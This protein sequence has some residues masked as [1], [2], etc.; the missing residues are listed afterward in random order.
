MAPLDEKEA[1][2]QVA[3]SRASLIGAQAAVALAQNALKRLITDRF[4]SETVPD[5]QPSDTLDVSPTPLDLQA[6]RDRGLR[7]RPDLNQLN[8]ALENRKLNIRFQRNQ[9][10][11]QLDLVGNLG[12]IGNGPEMSDA[13]GQVSD[14][15]APFHAMGAVLTMPLSNRRARENYRVVK[16]QREQVELQVRQ[17]RQEIVVQIQDG[18]QSAQSSFERVGATLEA[19]Q[20]AEAA[21]SAEERKL[22]NGKSTSFIVLQ[23]QQR[24]TSARFDELRARADYSKALSNLRLREGSTL[25]HHQIE[26]DDATDKP[27]R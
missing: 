1:Q 8:L 23:L 5:I 21:L 12:Y 14:R 25:M 7:L 16:D 4:E 19:R 24:L 20:F 18:I 10:Y 9:L 6:S 17:L 27:S 11:P 3:S 26:T 15:S 22:A 2:S 13:I